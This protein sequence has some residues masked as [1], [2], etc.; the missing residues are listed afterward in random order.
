MPPPVR[1]DLV[2][3]PL[4]VVLWSTGFIGAKYGLPYIEPITFLVIRFALASAVLAAWVVLARAAW[5]T[6]A[7]A[8]DAALVG[9]LLHAV[10]L[11]GIFTAIDLGTQA[12]VAALIIGLHP[13]LTAVIARQLLRERLSPSQWAGILLGVL[14]VALVVARK[15]AAGIGDGRGVGLCLVAL[16]AI[17]TASILQKNRA[18]NVPLRSTTLVQF[19]AA[20]AVV[21]PF[22]LLF[23]T[24]EVIWSGEL[25]FAMAWL[26]LV[27]SV[28][29]VSLLLFLI[30]RGAAS[31]VASLFFLVPPT[32]AMMAW[33]LFGE[34]M[35][36]IEIAGV[37]AAA[38][39]VLMVNRPA[40]LARRR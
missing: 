26:V 35:G 3:A 19:L 37:A 11:A 25:V 16:A 7:Q 40:F 14:G 2:A 23:E 34:V 31:N 4:F 39:G 12:G 30:R 22:S 15:L 32:T 10:H 29:A 38:A 13:V 20:T 9:I 28:G 27:L 6:W 5:P 24:R 36:P 1:P 18:G 21:I 17:S 8:R 33:G